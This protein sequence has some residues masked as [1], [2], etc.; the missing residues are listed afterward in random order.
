MTP[1]LTHK[2]ESDS[3][4]LSVG[5]VLL[6]RFTLLP[7]AAFVDC[8]RLSADSGDTSRPVNCRWT[9]MT[10]RGDAA[11]SSCG[12]QIT[13]CT[14]FQSPRRFDYLV[15]CGG[16]LP[17]GRAADAATLDY[18]RE[19]AAVGV[20][21][22]G[23]CTG[24]FAL[25]EAGLM[26]NR[27]CCV[28]WFHYHDLTARYP[29]VTPVADRLFVVDRD[30]ITCSGGTAA[31]DLAAWMIE[32]HLGKTWAQKSMHILLID[33]ARSGNTAQPQPTVYDRIADNRVRRAILLIEQ[34]LG[35]PITTPEL[36]S[37][38]NISRRQLERVFRDELGMSPSRFSR[39]L[40][41]R[42]GYWLLSN[43]DRSIADISIECGFTDNAHFARQF[44]ELF[45][46]TPA[47]VR[48]GTPALD[49]QTYS[50]IDQIRIFRKTA[51]PA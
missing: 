51:G 6:P 3:V 16:L 23:L 22:V 49:E 35:D 19:A 21:L 42:Y 34:H 32:R 17:Q 7:F 9:F 45:G 47:S 27:Q 38:L 33:R 44:R 46:F 50:D 30:R 40:R 43:T 36:A 14:T 2:S 41:L 24:P 37:M 29:D 25:I 15:V 28:S 4:K 8:L 18:L 39:T 1:D 48:R 12:A 10:V 20:P 5:I 13:P 11:Q 31:A 26:R